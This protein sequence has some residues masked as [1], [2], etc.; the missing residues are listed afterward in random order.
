[1][2][3]DINTP[4]AG[5]NGAAM[6]DNTTARISLSSTAAIHADPMSRFSDRPTQSRSDG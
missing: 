1:M 4:T 3:H 2:A 6:R 5:P